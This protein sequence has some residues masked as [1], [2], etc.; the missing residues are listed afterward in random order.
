MNSEFV[1]EDQFDDT[2]RTDYSYIKLLVHPYARYGYAVALYLSQM[3]DGCKS[4]SELRD[5]LIFA[6]E[7]GLNSFRME[8]DD[9]PGKDDKLVFRSI[10][11]E[12]LANEPS[13]VQGELSQIG[14]YLYPNVVTTDRD[15]SH[16]FQ[17]ANKM[18]TL[19]RLNKPLLTSFDFK[20]SFAPS[21]SKI[22]NGSI[23][24]KVPKGTLFEAICSAIT[25]VTPNKPS[26]MAIGRNTCVIPDL[27]RISELVDFIS[28]FEQMQQHQGSYQKSMTYEFPKEKEQKNVKKA[29]PDFKRPKIFHGNYPFAPYDTYYFG[30]S[31]LL[32]AIGY[33]SEMANETAWAERVLKAV[34]DRPL[35]IISYDEIK[36]EQ[37]N[38]HAI[39]LAQRGDLY[40]LIIAIN[41]RTLVG[42]S[43]I[44]SGRPDFSDKNS[45]RQIFKLMASRFLQQFSKPTFKDFISFRASYPKELRYLFEEYFMDTQPVDPHIRDIVNSAADYGAWLNRQAYF[46]AKADNESSPERIR[47]EKAKVLTIFESTALSAKTGQALIAQLSTQAG[48]LTFG[49]VT[50]SARTFI[51]AITSGEISL[52]D[53][54]HLVMSYLRLQSSAEINSGNDIKNPTEN[55]DL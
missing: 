15:A 21:V 43:E 3:S 51:D 49:D 24:Q 31:G 42:G 7:N 14:K 22:N 40:R 16:T 27:S 54:R 39:R 11:Y 45:T 10:H 36:Q 5:A 52:E 50:S 8:T 32:A 41:S 17:C 35:Y 55:E 28:L 29:K 44:E 4:E 48:R 18:I 13:L 25:T 37:Y 33:W 53:G 38:H 19:L 26:A 46:A 6:L 23:S 30:A 20:R 12:R 2:A 47:K 9:D 34:S 1:S